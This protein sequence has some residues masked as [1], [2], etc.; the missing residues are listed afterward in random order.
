MKSFSAENY[1]N[2]IHNSNFTA[3][4]FAPEKSYTMVNLIIT[5]KMHFSVDFSTSFVRLKYQQISSNSLQ[6]K[7]SSLISR[8]STE[9]YK[10]DPYCWLCDWLVIMDW[11]PAFGFPLYSH[12]ISIYMLLK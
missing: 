1:L 8:T 5:K 6:H 7:D 3:N 4:A 9:W 10:F 11:G 2:N 12:S